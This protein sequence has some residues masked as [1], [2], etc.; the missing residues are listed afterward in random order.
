M[1]HKDQS[2]QPRSA[3]H[4]ESPS[5]PDILPKNRFTIE[6]FMKEKTLHGEHQKMFTKIDNALEDEIVKFEMNPNNENSIFGQLTKELQND[7][8]KLG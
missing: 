6:R 2:F 7:A 3:G 8:M 1:Q 5:A 4:I